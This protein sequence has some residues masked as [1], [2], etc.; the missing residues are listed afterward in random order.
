MIALG[1]LARR[2]NVIDGR[3]TQRLSRLLTWFFYPALIYS[4]FVASFNAA[5][6]VQRWALPAGTFLIMLFGYLA[7][8]CVTAFIEM[9]DKKRKG[10]LFQCSTNNY[11]FLPMPLALL[12][13]GESGVA[14]LIY[15]TLGSEIAVWT[16][17]V[18]ALTG[19]RIGLAALR[20][21]VNP[22]L[23]AIAAAALTIVARDAASTAAAQQVVQSALMANLLS[24]LLSGL[25]LFGAAT[26]PVAMVVAGSRM[27][28]LRPHHVLTGLQFLVTAMRLI[29]IPGV[30]LLALF[31]VPL[32]PDVRQIL[33]LVAVM[34]AAISS[35]VLNE[36]YDGDPQF[37]ASSVFLTHV[38]AV[39]TIPFWLAF[40]F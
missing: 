31:A 5:A 38:T 28:E 2:L 16:L 27:A 8:R 26:I 21:L 20:H 12:Y 13:F 14:S 6:L 25:E 4:T 36:M 35:V 24:G 1:V 17:G 23:C 22:P 15:S 29:V 10:F 34:P 37:A 40:W 19:R 33:V 39:V 11:S 32:A 18:Y 7:G 3:D 9:P 30:I